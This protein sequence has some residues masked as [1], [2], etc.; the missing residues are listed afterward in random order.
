MRSRPGSSPRQRASRAA[1]SPT[2]SGTAR[3]SSGSCAPA[4]TRSTA[5]GA[6]PTRS[7]TDQ[8]YGVNASRFLA[9]E[10][11]PDQLVL[12]LY[13]QL[14]A[15]MTPNTFV[16]GEAAS[17]APL[18]GL[19]YRAMYLP[20]N[21]V[22]NDAFLETLRLLLVQ[23]TPAAAPARV[24][25]AARVAPPGRRIAVAGGCRRRSARSPYSLE[26]A[27]GAVRVHVEVPA[28]APAAEPAAPAAASRRAGA[29]ARCTPRARRSTQRPGRS[30]SR[31]RTA[32]SI[33]SCGLVE[34]RPCPGSGTGSR[35]VLLARRRSLRGGVAVRRGA[36]RGARARPSGRRSWARSAIWKIA[37]RAHN[38]ARRNAYVALPRVVPARAAR[39]RS[40]S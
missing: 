34:S 16:A 37:Y 6:V 23:E 24:R 38:G 7:G 39:R 33:S 36:P 25:D 21:S 14:A 32:P 26:A 12:S 29:S 18:D 35:L 17:V 11:E 1:R 27:R 20:P 40:R 8:V 13:G 10:D 22:A 4:A 15:G 2:C 9:A 30:T 5:P 28:R 19:R 3:G 31:V